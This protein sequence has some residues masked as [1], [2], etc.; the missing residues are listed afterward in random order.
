MTR[1]I[2]QLTDCHLFADPEQSLRDVVTWPR[3]VPLFHQVRQQ[4][5]DAELVLFTG[6][7]AHDE[8][9]G[10]YISVLALLDN[11]L[12]AEWNER[13]R[14]IPGNHDHRGWLGEL[15]SQH[16]NGPADRVTFHAQWPDWQLIGL[17]SQRPGELPGSL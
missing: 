2:V 8:A 13:V 1:R 11:S 16:T 6:D 7:T 10:T 5:P 3:L 4:V 15:F 17:D 9:R 12:G 14:I